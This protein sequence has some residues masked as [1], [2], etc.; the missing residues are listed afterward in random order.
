MSVKNII[1][2]KEITLYD[3]LVVCRKS[4]GFLRARLIRLLIAGAIG[5]VVGLAIAIMTP[6]RY[7][8]RITFV[9]EETKGMSPGISALAGQFGFDLGGGGGSIFSGDN[10]FL[11]LKSEA[12]IREALLTYYDTSATQTLA[13]RYMIANRLSKKWDKLSPTGA[14][15]FS[16]YVNK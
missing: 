9:V 3:F 16:K 6:E 4:V 2:K 11:F 10:V 15:S 12:L 7:I 14:I 5:L 13:D 1:Q 8:G